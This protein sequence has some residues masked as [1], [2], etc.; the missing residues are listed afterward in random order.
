MR[1]TRA[2]DMCAG[3]ISGEHRHDNKGESRL[4]REVQ[5]KK[6]AECS[7]RNLL[8]DIA[9]QMLTHGQRHDHVPQQKGPARGPE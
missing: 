2:Q 8:G 9:I 6:Q 3:H 5:A 7:G 4:G 1:L